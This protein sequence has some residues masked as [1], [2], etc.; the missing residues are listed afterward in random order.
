MRQKIIVDARV[1][2]FSTGWIDRV[3]GAAGDLTIALW[4]RSALH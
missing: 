2:S 4:K 1:A 3:G